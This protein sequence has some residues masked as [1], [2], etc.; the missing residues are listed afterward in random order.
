MLAWAAQLC[1][2][3]AL[4]LNLPLTSEARRETW[5]KG[6]TEPLCSFFFPFSLSFVSLVGM[7]WLT[8]PG[9]SSLSPLLLP[10]RP[11]SVFQFFSLLA[12]GCDQEH[13]F[14]NL[15]Y[16][17]LRII[18]RSIHCFLQR[19]FRVPQWL[20]TSLSCACLAL[21][22]NLLKGTQTES[23]PQPCFLQEDFPSSVPSTPFCISPGLCALQEMTQQRVVLLLSDFYIPILSADRIAKILEGRGCVAVGHLWFPELLLCCNHRA[24]SYHLIEHG[25]L[26]F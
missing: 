25:K 4:Y 16:S 2:P 21:P 12:S 11:P 14:L 8:N 17:A 22:R 24:E 6:D 5:G 18:S 10:N 15:A 3:L 1:I 23:Q 7:I 26:I 19:L 9:L 20:S 13:V